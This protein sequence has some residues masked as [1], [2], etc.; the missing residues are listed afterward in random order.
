MSVT[1]VWSTWPSQV[2]DSHIA[3]LT[4]K[5]RN[6]PKNSLTHIL[7]HTPTHRTPRQLHYHSSPPPHPPSPICTVIHSRLHSYVVIHPL[8]SSSI[9]WHPSIDP[10]PSPIIHHPLP[11]FSNL[12]VLQAVIV[13]RQPSNRTFY[14]HPK[15][16]PYRAYCR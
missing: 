12:V 15:P 2:L 11:P 5:T 14:R 10:H 7:T 9:P 4:P 3:R 1:G 6:Q 8:P 13:I 16:P